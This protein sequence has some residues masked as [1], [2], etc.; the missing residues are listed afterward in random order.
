VKIATSL[1]IRPLATATA[2]E[3][4]VVDESNLGDAE[5]VTANPAVHAIRQERDVRNSG[6]CAIRGPKSLPMG[7]GAAGLLPDT[8]RAAALPARW[9]AAR[10]RSQRGSEDG[11]VARR[12]RRDPS[13]QAPA[14][15]TIWLSVRPA[16]DRFSSRQGAEACRVRWAQ[17]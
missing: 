2:G 9:A 4:A 1:Q 7:R 12:S 5:D 3:V 6:P 14:A 15:F 17:G 11:V 13:L 16:R 8:P 10:L